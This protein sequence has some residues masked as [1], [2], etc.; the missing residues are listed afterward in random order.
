[1]WQ[2]YAAMAVMQVVGM[3]SSYQQS[4]AQAKSLRAAAEWDKY[5]ID[6]AKKQEVIK[7]NKQAK[8]LLSEKMAA[9]GAR[10]VR[11]GTGSTLMETQSVFEELDDARFWL[12]KGVQTELME[13]DYELG[14]S[15]AQNAWE[16]NTSLIEG[17]ANIGMSS[18][19]GYKSYSGGSSF[20]T[21]SPVTGNLRPSYFGTPGM[22]FGGAS[23]I[24]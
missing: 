14:A 3:V 20:M 22:N 9:I 19:M 17:V 16:R 10:G 21:S 23:I 4:K 24:E 12:E 13:T 6:L 5:K 2:L 7:Q 1:M 15:L 18:Y 11:G 8:M